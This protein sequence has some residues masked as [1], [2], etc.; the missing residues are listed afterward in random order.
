MA[1]IFYYNI[2]RLIMSHTNQGIGDEPPKS[3][4]DI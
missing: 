1:S 3:T 4:K 2:L